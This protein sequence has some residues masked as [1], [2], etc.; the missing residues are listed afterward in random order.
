MNRAYYIVRDS[1]TNTYYS[2]VKHEGA[3]W[4]P[5][6]NTAHKF[7]TLED[8]KLVFSGESFD[9]IVKEVALTPKYYLQIKTMGG[10]VYWNGEFFSCNLDRAALYPTPE[11]AYQEMMKVAKHDR[12]SV[13]IIM[14]MHEVQ[15]RW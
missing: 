9:V 11:D 14:E 4:N 6:K 10:A 12:P 15:Y 1:Q 8:A 5:D 7:A 13:Q 2:D 3:Y